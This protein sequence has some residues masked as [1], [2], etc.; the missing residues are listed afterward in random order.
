VSEATRV[1][2]CQACGKELEEPPGLEERAPCPRCGSAARHVMIGV[3]DTITVHESVAVK[4]R[5]G[6][7]GRPFREIKQGDD[8]HRKT[9]RWTVLSRLIDREQ[10]LYEERIVDGETGE[11]IR[12]VREPL[13]KHRGHGSAKRPST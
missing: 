8:L 12:D 13:S 5:H 1:V 2:T 10:D 6:D 7:R 3:R 4:A 11:V 9:G